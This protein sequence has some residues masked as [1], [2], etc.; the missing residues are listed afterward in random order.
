MSNAV[1]DGIEI[2]APRARDDF[3]AVRELFVE[4]ADFLGFSLAYQGFEAELNE[5]ESMYAPPEGA[6]LL[7]RVDGEAAGA[8][9]LRPI[10]PGICEM[11]RLYVKP[12][13][14]GIRSAEGL[15]LGRELAVRI[16]D[17]GRAL[18]YGRM[19]LDTVPKLAAARRLY[20]SMGF[21]EIPAYYP[22]PVPD[23]IFLELLL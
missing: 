9:A 11:K 7:A 19:R 16:V 22:T 10:A 23:T 6:L 4:Y 21:K 5:I 8:V 3:E 14:R 12:G 2:I 20:D 1:P 17:C 18:G 15:S 13:F